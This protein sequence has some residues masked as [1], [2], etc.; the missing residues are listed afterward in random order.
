M[1]DSCPNHAK[2]YR[3]VDQTVTSDDR[4]FCQ[5]FLSWCLYSHMALG[6]GELTMLIELLH[7][8]GYK[9]KSA[10]LLNRFNAR[11][12]C[13]RCESVYFA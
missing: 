4:S 2:A 13:K 6:E 9:F 12:Y 11:N 3:P 5:V 1:C 7:L 10:I 8:H